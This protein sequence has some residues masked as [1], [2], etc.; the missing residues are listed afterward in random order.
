[1]DKSY[2]TFTL[3]PLPNTSHAYRLT[4]TNPPINLITYTFLS[5]FHS[6]LTAL[7]TSPSPPKVLIISSTNPHFWLSHLDLH[8]ASHTSPLPS[9]QDAGIAIHNLTSIFSLLGTLSTIFIAEINGRAVAGGNVIACN[10]DMRF[11]GPSATFGVVEVGGGLVHVG[12]LQALT[13]LLGPGRA[14]EVMLGAKGVDAKEA[15]RIGL[16][17][18]A[19]GSEEELKGYVEELA[20]RIALFPRGGI[21]GTK[22]GV[23]EC[24]EGTGSTG[25]DGER[26]G[27]LIGTEET[28]RAIDNILGKKDYGEVGEF[29]LGLPDNIVDTWLKQ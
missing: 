9:H 6:F 1:M 16:A 25:K 8:I 23:R 13:K 11:A 14:M 3:T 12:A 26:F 5:E 22:K 19:F 27:G 20:G 29:E 4:I 2:T 15:E 24:L 7:Q 21:E 17:N 10:M 28:Q 18:R